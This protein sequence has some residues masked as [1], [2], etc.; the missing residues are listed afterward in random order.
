V[1]SREADCALS[2]RAVAEM[3]TQSLA[4]LGESFDTLEGEVPGTAARE[5][6][7]EVA[8]D[9]VTGKEPGTWTPEEKKAEA[10]TS[11]ICDP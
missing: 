1:G 7:C 5:M 6:C 10:E 9:G 3:R 2:R 11:T 8:A 4:K